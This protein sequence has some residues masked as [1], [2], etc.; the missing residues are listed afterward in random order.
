VSVYTAAL[1]SILVNASSSPTDLGLLKK[2]TPF[3]FIVEHLLLFFSVIVLLNIA[4]YPASEK[5]VSYST[6]RLRY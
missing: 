1:Y 3:T 6:T 2:I 5:M 4:N